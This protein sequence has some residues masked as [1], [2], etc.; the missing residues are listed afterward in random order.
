MHTTASKKND[1][2]HV[3]GVSERGR[4]RLRLLAVALRIPMGKLVELMID[5][6][7]DER[8]DEIPVDMSITRKIRKI[9]KKNPRPI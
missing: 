9:I 8:S 1:N 2:L 6:L 3:R 5:R 7:W 4:L